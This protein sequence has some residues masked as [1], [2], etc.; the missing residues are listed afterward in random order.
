MSPTAVKMSRMD[1][2]LDS[3]GKVVTAE[4]IENEFRKQVIV[5]GGA[6]EGEAYNQQLEAW[7]GTYR[8]MTKG[9][10]RS[11]AATTATLAIGVGI[12]AVIAFIA[13]IAGGGILAF[14]LILVI[15]AVIAGIASLLVLMAT[16]LKRS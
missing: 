6:L 15:G 10:K 1:T 2:Y 7:K 12:A 11:V 5:Q 14:I 16:S 13:L 9:D 4:Q 8:K 3:K